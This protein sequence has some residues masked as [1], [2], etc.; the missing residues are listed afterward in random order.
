[1]SSDQF[2][3]GEKIMLIQHP[4]YGFG[5]VKRNEIGIIRSINR[6]RK[7]VYCDFPSQRGWKGILSDLIHATAMQTPRNERSSPVT[8]TRKSSTTSINVEAE[9]SLQRKIMLEAE[10]KRK[11]IQ[12]DENFARSLELSFKNEE[13]NQR[14]LNNNNSNRNR[15]QNKNGG[16]RNSNKEDEDFA[17]SLDLS[18]K[19]E[20]ENQRKMSNNN[21]NKMAMQNNNSSRKMMKRQSSHES[22]S[23]HSQRVLDEQ[24]AAETFN[25]IA[26]TTIQNNEM[27]VDADFP[28]NYK[29]LYGSLE[30]NHKRAKEGY[31][32]LPVADSWRRGKQLT[33]SRDGNKMK[34][35]VFRGEPSAEDI[36]QGALG[37]C[38]FLSALAVV[39]TRLD[40]INKIFVSKETNNIG[41]YQVRL[42]KDGN[43]QII[44]VDSLFPITKNGTLAYANGARCQLWPAILEKAFAKIYGSY[45]AIESGTCIEALQ[46]LT[47]APC[48]RVVLDNKDVINNNSSSN[49]S[50]SSSNNQQEDNFTKEND[51]NLSIKTLDNLW[52]ELDSCQ[53]AG[54]L[55]AA[56]C[57]HSGIDRSIYEHVGLQGS[58]AYSIL[59]VKSIRLANNTFERIIQ[60]RNPWGR[61]SW[62]GRWSD[63]SA[64]W[65]RDTQRSADYYGGGNAF[66]VF[67]MSL[68]DFFKFFHAID[69]CHV[70]SEKTAWTEVRVASK[71]KNISPHNNVGGGKDSS[72]G[73]L[74]EGFD[75]EVLKNCSCDMTIS[76]ENNRGNEN[77][78]YANIGLLILR[79]ATHGYGYV[80]T[81]GRGPCAA[82]SYQ[83]QLE[84]GRYVVF[85]I[86]ANSFQDQN[87]VLAVHS[88]SPVLVTRNKIPAESMARG[89]ILAAMKN[90]EQ[91][92]LGGSVVLYTNKEMKGL[93]G[94]GGITMV[95]ANRDPLRTCNVQIDCSGCEN[96]TSSRDFFV[97]EDEIHPNRAMIVQMFNVLQPNGG[98]S[99]RMQVQSQSGVN[100]GN[101]LNLGNVLN[102]LNNNTNNNN[103]S[104]HRPALI[105]GGEIH[106]PVTL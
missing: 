55:M 83:L 7:E 77:Q 5:A 101:M 24:T 70:R 73:N 4:K 78:L 90:G 85:P 2:V 53:E 36:Q 42:C 87:M 33:H 38:Y 71:L 79:K 37:D 25:L 26:A 27:F 102:G 12:E 41:A 62:K 104:L 47:G 69:I 61:S 84:K 32:R 3:V 57:G 31:G 52:V 40:I 51:G 58:H 105:A 46:I 59:C 8:T 22:I 86:V 15:H 81:S 39:A 67:F 10:Q 17:R 44:T 82:I 30:N 66:G 65:T 1:M 20:D 28:P 50:N 56:S 60:L 13:Q 93:A 96:L 95:V 21:N 43:W 88:S 29:S 45:A 19:M 98:Y 63:G 106:T 75:I 99:W 91:S 72:N 94:G 68:E 76:Q 9:Y 49:S 74:I 35:Q 92:N 34:Y 6:K 100:L 103:I 97:T 48:F 16:N 14:M 64:E 54:Y 11:S 18:F 89:I 80:G 23:L